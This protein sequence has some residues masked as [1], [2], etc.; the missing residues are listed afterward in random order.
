MRSS[1]PETFSSDHRQDEQQ[2]R[3]SLRQIGFVH[4]DL[5]DKR[6]DRF[7]GSNVAINATCLL[8]GPEELAGGGADQGVLDRE[9][10]AQAG[11]LHAHE[12]A[13]REDKCLDRFRR[14]GLAD[15]I[16]DVDG[17]EIARGDEAIHVAEI[18]VVSIDVERPG[19][20]SAVIAV[21]AAASTRSGRCR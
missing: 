5:G 7:G 10:F 19:Q 21:S 14:R 20:A 1:G 4:R 17:E 9:R 8:H 3:G 12:T 18:D 13:R 11:N 2:L 6:R 16:S 15:V